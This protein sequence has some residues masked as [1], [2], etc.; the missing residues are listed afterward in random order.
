M[1]RCY[2]VTMLRLRVDFLHVPN[3]MRP[4]SHG[5][6]AAFG[7]VYRIELNRLIYITDES[8]PPKITASKSFINTDEVNGLIRYYNNYQSTFVTLNES[9]FG[10]FQSSI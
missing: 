4:L 6:T 3:E 10:T 2:D 1:L 9:T 5:I 8:L 7:S